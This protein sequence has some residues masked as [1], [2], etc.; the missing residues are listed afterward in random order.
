[1]THTETGS[2]CERARGAQRIQPQAVLHR[3]RQ[4]VRHLPAM[5]GAVI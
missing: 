1:M 5:T 3:V 4:V 2:G